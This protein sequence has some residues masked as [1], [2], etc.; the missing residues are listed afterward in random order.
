MGDS[1]QEQI[2]DLVMGIALLR[3][4]DMSKFRLNL[5]DR[6]LVELLSRLSNVMGI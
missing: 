4:G 5:I 2:D 1:G 3:L 6:Q